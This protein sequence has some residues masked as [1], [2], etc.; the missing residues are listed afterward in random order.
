M[1]ENVMSKIFWSFCLALF[2]VGPALA[3]EEVTN[4]TENVCPGNWVLSKPS[5]WVIT[6]ETGTILALSGSTVILGCDKKPISLEANLDGVSV[7]VECAPSSIEKGLP[8]VVTISIVC[9]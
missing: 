8:D 2:L 6:N 4:S 3:Q 7:D 1:M 9:E 5:G